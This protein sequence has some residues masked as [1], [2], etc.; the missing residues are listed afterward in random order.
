MNCRLYCENY[1]KRKFKNT[2]IEFC[3]KKARELILNDILSDYECEHYKRE[4]KK[5]V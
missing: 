5:E 2:E 3:K 1:E 4:I